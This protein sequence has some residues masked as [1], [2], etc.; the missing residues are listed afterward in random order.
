M[1]ISYNRCNFKDVRPIK[2]KPQAYIINK[3]NHAVLCLVYCGLTLWMPLRPYP[4]SD[5]D[6]QTESK[7]QKADDITVS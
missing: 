6:L 5:A 3:A 2:N 4:G 1:A 7:I